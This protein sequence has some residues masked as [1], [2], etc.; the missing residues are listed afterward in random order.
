MSKKEIKNRIHS[1]LNALFGKNILRY[2][3]AIANE[4]AK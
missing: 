3:Y 2:L 1:T 4:M